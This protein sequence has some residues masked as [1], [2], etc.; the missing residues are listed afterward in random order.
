MS[1]AEQERRYYDLNRRVYPLF[2]PFYDLVA[3]PLHSLRRAV[4]EQA[5]LP[6]GARVLDVATGTGAQAL[7]FAPRAREVVG[8]DLS[9]AMLRI[10]R[11][12][13]R[14]P[15]VRFVQGDA[16]RLPW[17]DSDFDASCISFGLHE[18][19]SEVR[20]R[21]LGELSRVTRPDGKVVVVDYALPESRPFAWLAVHMISLYERDHYADFVRSDLGAALEQAGLTVISRRPALRG[22][23][24]VIV[25][26]RAAQ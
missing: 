25:S 7:A 19:P 12:K 2:A 22:V 17:P 24:T 6:P 13:N 8:L 9:E 20:T 10:A 14:F 4:V 16:T 5:A 11:A 1:P 21:V 26:R 18:M 23:A 3:S 15:Q